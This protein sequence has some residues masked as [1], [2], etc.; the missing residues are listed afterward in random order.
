MGTG[1]SRH[2]QCVAISGE[3][4]VGKSA[5]LDKA[6]QMVRGYQMIPLYAACYREE[7]EFFL[8]PWNDI[9]WEVEQCVENGLLERSIT[10]EEQAQLDRL[11]VYKRQ[12]IYGT[13]PTLIPKH[14]TL[15]NYIKIFTLD[16]GLYRGC[17]FYTSRCV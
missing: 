10:E 3:D 11:D 5:L 17:L 8:R 12:E 1:R 15:A 2:P 14:P 13:P 7:S 6:K 4:G 9:F 16:D